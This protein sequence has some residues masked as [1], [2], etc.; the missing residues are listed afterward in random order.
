M[1]SRNVGICFWGI[2]KCPEKIGDVNNEKQKNWQASLIFHVMPDIFE[3]GD[4]EFKNPTL[5]TDEIYDQMRYEIGK[6]CK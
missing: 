3:I 1:L 4:F 5:H 2:W 6:F